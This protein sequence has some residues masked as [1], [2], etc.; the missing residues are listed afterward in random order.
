MLFAVVICFIVLNEHTSYGSSNVINMRIVDEPTS[1]SWQQNSH[2]NRD[3]RLQMRVTPSSFSGP[4]HLRRLTGRCFTKTLEKYEY[5]F[6]PF[7]NI[8]QKEVG[9]NTWNPYQGILGVW[10]EWKIKDNKFESM[11]MLMGDQC[12]VAPRQTEVKLQCGKA[13][14]I[15]SVTEPSH[16]EYLLVFSTPLTCHNHS[17]LVYPTLSKELQ[18]QWN[19]LLG[20]LQLEHITEKGYTKR[21]DGIF[22]SA[23]YRLR[24]DNDAAQKP[25]KEGSN[26]LIAEGS[27]NKHHPNLITE[28]SNL[29]SCN[30]GYESL[31]EELEQTKVQLQRFL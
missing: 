9:T 11:M 20:D 4:E 7:V 25:A 10:Q 12:G 3:V 19:V 23:G 6:C 8:T 22:Q 18:T 26:D 28:F 31:K 21:L 24:D 27:A 13:N 5:E 15:V 1:Y 14:E 16:C 29:E 30:A 17:L 2:N